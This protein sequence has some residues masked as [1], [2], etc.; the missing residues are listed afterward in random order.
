VS[1][2]QGKSLLKAAGQKLAAFFVKAHYP[3]I[4]QPLFAYMVTNS[5][6]TPPISI[7]IFDLLL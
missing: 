3:K 1:I 4:A 2:F 7:T 5:G 6:Y